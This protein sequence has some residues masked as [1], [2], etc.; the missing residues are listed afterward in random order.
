M[1]QV[2][3]SGMDFSGIVDHKYDPEEAT[4]SEKI[5]FGA[6]DET[7]I[8]GNIL[9]YGTALADS[10]FDSKITFDDALSSINDQRQRDVFYRNPKMFGIDPEQE[11]AAI[12]TGRVGSALI[13]PVTWVI[14][15]AKV[16][17]IGRLGATA[18]GASVAAGDAALRDKLIYGETDPFTI[19]VSAA[20]GG[21]A[22]F[23]SS[24]LARRFN[25]SGKRT[26]EE[27]SQNPDR[28]APEADNVG[29]VIPTVRDEESAKE[30]MPSMSS[31]I[32]AYQRQKWWG[33]PEPI[34]VSSE[35][36][37][38]DLVRA[39]NRRMAG[40]RQPLAEKEAASLEEATIKIT[41]TKAIDE[42]IE[43]TSAFAY[44]TQPIQE[45]RQALYALEERIKGAR[46]TDKVELER[47]QGL[48]RKKLE[49]A[50]KKYFDTQLDTQLTKADTDGAILEDLNNNGELTNGIMAKVLYEG[51][52]PIIGSL[53]GYAASG[54]IGDEDDDA[55]T[56]GMMLAGAYIGRR[57][58][59]MRNSN[60]TSVQKENGA[61]MID[62]GAGRNLR[63]MVKMHSAG[64]L[65]TQLDSMGGY[66][67]I[68]G[69]M[70]FQRPGLLQMLWKLGISGKLEDSWER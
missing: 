11:E 20:A 9:R 69:N 14:P 39:H 70:L 25:N 13:D 32:R 54:I 29:Q 59:I 35:S 18:F 4:T 49:A 16:D 44:S 66:A 24:S 10:M 58:N 67:K 57:H 3:Y 21:G 68:I 6:D 26:I 1:K 7:M 17:K 43:S 41:D 5:A 51:T 47:L 12:L 30:T 65:S 50:Q 55:L 37:M 8:G 45:A 48:A 28:V 40:Y 31:V 60:L 42:K 33:E 2:D 19:G 53:G 23:V 63:T 52:R 36:P 15:W 38:R 64:T 56:L 62:D 22:S 34:Q 46:G 61:L 27:A